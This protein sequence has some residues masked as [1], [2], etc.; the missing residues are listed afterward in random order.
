MNRLH[1]RAG[2]TGWAVGVALAMSLALAAEPALGQSTLKVSGYQVN[3]NTLLDPKALDAVLLPLLGQRTLQELHQAA[4]TVQ[5]L[6]AAEGYGAVVAYVPP[7][8]GQ[9]GIVAI[10]VVEG[11]IS[12]VSVRGAK[13]FP[14]AQV[15]ASLPA[16]KEGVTP[17]LRTIDTELRLANENPAKQVQVL[18]KP[19]QAAGQSDAELVVVEQPVQRLTLGLDNTGN[20]R[21]GEARASLGW[22]HADLTGRDDVLS[23]QL[24]TSPSKPDQVRVLSGGYRLPLYARHLALDAFAAY[25]DVDGGASQSLA[26]DLSFN[27]RG[28]ILGARVLWYLP[29]WGE[30]DQRLGLGIDRRAYLNR[31]NIDGLPSGACGPAGES[32]TVTPL[33]VE[34]SLQSATT[35]AMAFNA[36][37]HHNLGLGGTHTGQAAFEAVRP[38]ARRSY[39][40]LR[41]GAQATLPVA[42][43]WQLKA[44]LTGQVSRDALVPG[45]QFGLGGAQSLRGYDER[46]LVGDLGAVLSLELGGPGFG[47]GPA[48]WGHLRPH[49]FV[50]AG[51]ASNQDDAP[52]VDVRTR[53]TAASVGVGAR[54]ALGALTA[55][56]D[57]AYPLKAAARTLRGDAR[58]HVALQYGF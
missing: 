29:R 48:G 13:R 56:I 53:C 42:E 33:S 46:E 30:F 49:A 12:S 43:D 2:A 57:L 34:Y 44:R 47:P 19:G 22:L 7:Q 54:Y 25:S 37:L 55:R 45:E 16:L 20:A 4:T 3:G 9:D 27:G 5:N 11:K 26:G 10:T 36:S 8:T 31:C 40:A 14:A 39:S 15:R 24:Q 41:F 18:I 17:N 32:V 28:R 50:D 58:A 52:C 1:V 35:V 38:G 51:I 23:V 6:Y 21:T